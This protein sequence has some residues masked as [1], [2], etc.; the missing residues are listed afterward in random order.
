MLFFEKKFFGKLQRNSK[1]WSCDRILDICRELLLNTSDITDWDLH[2]Q[3]VAQML[4]V[5]L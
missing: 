1:F 3:T 5:V 2:G 4:P